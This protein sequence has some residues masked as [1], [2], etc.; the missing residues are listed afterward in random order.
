MRDLVVIGGGPGGY[1]AALRAAQLGMRVTLVEKNSLGG[2]CLNRGCIPTKA[3]YQSAQMLHSIKQFKEFGITVTGTDFDFQTTWERKE[4]V[5]SQL[6]QGI[7]SLLSA[8]GVEVITG[9]ATLSSPQ[10]VRVGD[11][12]IDAKRILI[13]TGS[14]CSHLPIP[15]ADLPHVVNSDQLLEQQEVPQRL[16]VIGGGVIGLE[17][18]SI[19]QAF[20]SQVTVL[21][22]MPDLLPGVDKEISKRLRIFLKR[23]GID[24]ITGARVQSISQEGNGL[25]VSAATAKGEITA[26]G[27]TVLI[28][29][30][31][32]PYT[33]GL[34]LEAGGVET[35][36]QGFIVT[37][38]DFQTN[39]PS[40]YAIGDV[41]GGAMLAHV[42]S[43]EGCV[44]VERMVGLDTQVAYQAIPAV[45]FT[46]PEVAS[47][48]LSEEAA[49]EQGIDYRVG[50]FQFA[51][52]S[53]AVA[54]GETDGLVKVLTDS[55]GI[56]IGAHIIGPH[57][58][59]LIAT[60]ALAVKERLT[61]DQVA[62]TIHAHPTLSEAW[63]EAV[64]DSDQ[65]AIHLMPRRRGGR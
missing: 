64:L 1:V 21:E 2:T 33:A 17:F 52:N 26:E 37:N 12:T 35:T 8:N 18:A 34:N 49:K 45:V 19:F 60:A 32:R 62:S 38:D 25:T 39:V 63:L 61:N 13:A 46:S 44:A 57:A 28:A 11:Q 3:Y 16:V 43:A 9:E 47:V 4:Q 31:R 27:D 7:A 40:I 48:G 42:A 36:P 5:V 15:G 22:Y 50:K 59:D 30:G 55:D 56:I 53:K 54:M 10:Q 6:V 58:A 24:I 65:R 41:I 23:Q 14:S 20:G 29:T 51:A